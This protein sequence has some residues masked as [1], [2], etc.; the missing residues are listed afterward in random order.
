MARFIVEMVVDDEDTESLPSFSFTFAQI[1]NGFPSASAAAADSL[2]GKVTKLNIH[3]VSHP[4][5]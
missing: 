4:I 2:T 3:K 5:N 1:F